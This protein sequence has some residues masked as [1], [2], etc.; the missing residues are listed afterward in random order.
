MDLNRCAYLDIE[1]SWPSYQCADGR[2]PSSQKKRVA[3]QGKITIIGIYKPYEG[4]KQLIRPDI[5]ILQLARLLDDVDVLLTY[6][7]A[8]FDLPVI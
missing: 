6:N 5:S 2:W 3:R 4:T 8:R 7:G 1:T